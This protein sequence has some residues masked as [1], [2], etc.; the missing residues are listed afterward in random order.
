MSHKNK[1]A[2]T[3]HTKSP[4]PSSQGPR[5]LP[6]RWRRRHGLVRH[7]HQIRGGGGHTLL[8]MGKKKNEEK[9][10]SCGVAPDGLLQKEEQGNGG[11]AGCRTGVRDIL[12]GSKP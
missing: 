7:A 11:A 8:N 5:R 12:A 6:E 4:R 10:K 3:N 2:L 1:R 9:K